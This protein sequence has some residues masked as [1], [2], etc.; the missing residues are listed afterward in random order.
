MCTRYLLT[1]N[2]FLSKVV[3]R[4]IMMFTVPQHM[5]GIMNQIVH[6]GYNGSA[7]IEVDKCGV[8]FF[9]ISF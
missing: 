8:M 2:F 6:F 7:R 3:Y 1:V 5:R 4:Y 9:D